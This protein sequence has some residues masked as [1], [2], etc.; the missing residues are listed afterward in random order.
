MFKKQPNPTFPA[1]VEINIP[2]AA[3][4]G[5]L[6]VVFRR[7]GRKAFTELLNKVASGQL[8]EAAA[9][10]DL[11]DG[12]DE[13]AEDSMV[14]VPYGAAALESLLDTFWGAG[15]ALTQAYVRAQSEARAKN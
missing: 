7:M 13:T 3:E 8:S 10:G 14:T 15:G 4:P 1:R 2:D 11:L 6:H 5:A 9:M 12:W